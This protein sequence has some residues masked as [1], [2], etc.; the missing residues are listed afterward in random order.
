M[1][2]RLA[3]LI[4]AVLALVTLFSVSPTAHAP[5]PF[6]LTN[7]GIAT[8]PPMEILYPTADLTV[9]LVAGNT[10]IKATMPSGVLFEIQV[11]VTI[12]TGALT[13]A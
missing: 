6:S 13:A 11:P 9:S 10:D 12:V 3:R 2:G 7:K 5:P 1:G 8:L 4:L